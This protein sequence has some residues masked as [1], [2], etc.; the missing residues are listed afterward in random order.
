MLVGISG[1]LWWL[2]HDLLQWG[3]ILTERRL[4]VTH[5]VA[6]AATLV[7]VGG[8]LPLHIRLAWRTRRN[9]ISGFLTFLL[10]ASLGLSGLLLYYSGED[11]RD[12]VR[13]AHIGA[14]L[15]GSLAVPIHIWFGK[16][17]QSLGIA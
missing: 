14:G 13:W 8:L 5:G 15:I 16:Q 10:M 6:A 2:L 7:V 9:L 11:W 4:L 12:W 17:R 1:A 3:W